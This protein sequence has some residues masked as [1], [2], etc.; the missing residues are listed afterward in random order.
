MMATCVASYS[1]DGHPRL[2]DS[3]LQSELFGDALADA[4]LLDVPINGIHI[5]NGQ[6]LA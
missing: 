5:T 2:K 6:Q 4:V 3:H 1:Y